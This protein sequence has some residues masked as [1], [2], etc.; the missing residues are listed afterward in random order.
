MSI[1]DFLTLTTIALAILIV[2]PFLGRY[3][4]RVMEG[5]RVF[6]SPILRPVERFVY[7]VCGI[8]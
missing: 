3:I 6:L 5:E 8:D 4:Y 1:G 2:T 7:R